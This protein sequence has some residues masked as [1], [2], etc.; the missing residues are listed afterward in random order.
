MM[1]KISCFILIFAKFVASNRI[2]APPKQD[3][4]EFWLT[5]GSRMTMSYTDS[6]GFDIPLIYN[7]SDEK[8]YARDFTCT[9]LILKDK[10]NKTDINT[11]IQLISIWGIK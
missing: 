5:V 2:V 1:F 11:G 7:I 6:N 8:F 4:Y 3:V 9:G 10:L